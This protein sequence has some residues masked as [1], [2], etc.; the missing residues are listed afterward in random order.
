MSNKK[1]LKP[2]EVLKQ[3]QESLSESDAGSDYDIAEES[4]FEIEEE[5]DYETTSDLD[6]GNE[7]S[8]NGILKGKDGTNWMQYTVNQEIRGRIKTENIFREKFGIRNMS[9]KYIREPLDAWKLLINQEIINNIIE[10]TNLKAKSKSFSLNL[11][12]EELNI[13]IGLIYLRGILGL[14][15]TPLDFIWGHEFGPPFFKT[16]MA[17]NRFTLILKYLRFEI[18]GSRAYRKKDKFAHIRKIFEIFTANCFL[19]YVPNCYVTI[20]EQLLPLKNRCPFLQFIP[21][22]PDKYGIK[23]WV[24]VDNETKYCFNQFPYLGKNEVNDRGGEKVGD[25]V[26]KTDETFIQKRV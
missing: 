2:S 20:D 4:E 8:I 10:A 18:P 15:K 5:S 23:L 16:H 24:A 1:I 14:R 21:S 22:K 13:F 11:Q 12:K 3:L 26:V 7:T 9:K 6:N 25:Y 17:R 19:H